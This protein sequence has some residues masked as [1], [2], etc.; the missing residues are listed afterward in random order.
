MSDTETRVP[1]SFK[2]TLEKPTLLKQSPVSVF[3]TSMRPTLSAKVSVSFKMTLSRLTLFKQSAVSV[4]VTS[5][6]PTL[7]VLKPVPI[8]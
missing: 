1:M 5:I 3:V 6:T 7:I 4:S 2:M 8:G